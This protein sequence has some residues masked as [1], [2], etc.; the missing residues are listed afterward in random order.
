MPLGFS[1]CASIS[2][3]QNNRACTQ[4]HIWSAANTF[5]CSPEHFEW[6]YS[7][8]C[9]NNGVYHDTSDVRKLTHDVEVVG[10]GVHED[11]TKCVVNWLMS[12]CCTTVPD[13]DC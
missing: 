6:N 12:S 13:D 4:T 11:G 2:S 8:S 5:V 7:S 9:D 1:H 3:V 10:W